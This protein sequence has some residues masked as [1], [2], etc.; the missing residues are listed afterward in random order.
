MSKLLNVGVLGMGNAGGNIAQ[1][2]ANEGFAAV[3][4]NGAVQD[5]ENL[6]DNVWKFPIGD[7]RGTGKNRDTAKQFL[8]ENS[9]ILDDGKMMEFLC[10][11]DIIVIPTSIGGGFG[12]GASI[13]MA[14]MLKDKFPDKS[15]IPCGAFPLESEGYT[16]QNHGVEWLKELKESDRFAYMFYDNNRFANKKPETMCELI[17]NEIVQMLK[18]FRGDFTLTDISGGMDQRDMM[19]LTS[20]PGR[21]AGYVKTIEEADIIDESIVKTMLSFIK[22]ES[23]LAELVDDKQIIAS[24]FQYCLDSSFDKYIPSIRQDMQDILGEHLNDYTN[25]HT[26]KDNECNI[27]AMVMAGL[28]DSTLRIDRMINKR[29][30]AADNILTRKGAESKLTKASGGD[31]R[32]KIGSNSFATGMSP[33]KIAV[34]SVNNNGNKSTTPTS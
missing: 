18:I 29:D 17:N 10:Q 3:A 2:A 33:K 8:E 15:I 31:S 30:K 9:A 6:G 28:S 20:I 13:L 27:V 12:S 5:L 11:N 22:D 23:G 4:V 21:I 34:P 26:A 16:A 32:L 1:A 24:A 19:T 7:G 25:Y 14:N